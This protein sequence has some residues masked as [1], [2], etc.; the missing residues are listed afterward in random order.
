MAEASI[1]FELGA[2]KFS[3]EGSEAWVAKQLEYVISQLPEL[4]K[5]AEIAPPPAHIQP[6]SPATKTPSSVGSLASHIK[7]KGGEGNQVQRFLATADWLRLKGEKNLKS[8]LVS[9]ALQENHQKKLSNPADSLNLN[10]AKGYCEK[11][12]DGFFITPEGLKALG[13]AE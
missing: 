2:I 13:H 5:A 10:V 3:S 4:S 8:T 1:Q 6:N 9:K 7:E 11:T 12:P